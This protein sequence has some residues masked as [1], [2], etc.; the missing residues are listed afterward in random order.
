[1]AQIPPPWQRCRPPTTCIGLD[2]EKM[3]V[4]YKYTFPWIFCNNFCCHKFSVVKFVFGFIFYNIFFLSTDS[5][6]HNFSCSQNM[7]YNFFVTIVLLLFSF[8]IYYF[9]LHIFSPHNFAY[10]SCYNFVSSYR[11]LFVTIF[12]TNLVS[13]VLFVKKIIFS[14]ICVTK[15][16]GRNFLLVQLFLC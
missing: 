1:M 13:K 2:F 8:T 10:F 7:F 16:F 3:C 4:L 14:Q 5:F 12:F 9:W 11:H 6:C 15:C